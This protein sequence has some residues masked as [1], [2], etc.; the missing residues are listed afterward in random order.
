MSVDR[1]CS[2]RYPDG[3]GFAMVPIKHLTRMMRAWILDVGFPGFIHTRNPTRN[4]GFM[5]R[6]LLY[7]AS[8]D[9]ESELEWIVITF[10][11][12]LMSPDA[13][14]RF[15]FSA[16]DDDRAWAIHGCIMNTT[17]ADESWSRFYRLSMGLKLRTLTPEDFPLSVSAHVNPAL[18]YVYARVGW[19]FQP[20]VR[21]EISDAWYQVAFSKWDPDAVVDAISVG[22][23]CVN[24]VDPAR[25]LRNIADEH[26][27][28]GALCR[29]PPG[30]LVRL[31]RGACY[32]GAIYRSGNTDKHGWEDLEDSIYHCYVC[33]KE[34]EPFMY[35]INSIWTKRSHE[36][37]EGHEKMLKM[38]HRY[39]DIQHAARRAALYTVHA[40]RALLGGRGV[41][42]IVAKFVYATRSQDPAA[43]HK[44]N[45]C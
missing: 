12:A 31:A 8:L 22:R 42:T 36:N 33:G 4:V 7:A 29:S 14:R 41:A 6:A 43:W 20:A 1:R 39:L 24:V 9:R 5:R 30:D 27:H 11:D 25:L 10:K 23:S 32:N 18:A 44:K 34:Y 2:R 37:M 38:I 21:R 13:E 15:R 16:G 19:Y 45:V 17:S 26:G 3:N 28:V 35:G 40:F